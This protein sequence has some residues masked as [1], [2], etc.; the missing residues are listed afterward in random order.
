MATIETTYLGDL[1][2]EA[3]HVFSGNKTITDAPLD[4]KG[5]AESFSPSDLLT[6]ALGSCMITIM[7]IAAREHGINIDGTT[8]SLTKIM[9]SDP[10]RVS[11]VQVVLNFPE[12]NY[13]EKEK[14]I[15]ERSALTCPVAKSLH[16]DLL[17]NVTF[18]Y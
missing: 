11:E 14:A 16:P 17:Q 5:K 8:C 3:T 12:G 13:T 1:R 15:L 7:G 10:R 18:N 4:N 6:A 2:T 9:A